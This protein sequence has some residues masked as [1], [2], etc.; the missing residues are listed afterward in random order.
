MYSKIG[1]I[2]AVSVALFVLFGAKIAI[3]AAIPQENKASVFA[4]VGEVQIT[5]PVYKAEF[6]K[7]VRNRLFHNSNPSDEMIGKIQREVGARLVTNALVLN[8]AKLR[9]LQPDYEAV[10]QEVANFERKMA[11]DAGWQK[12][13]EQSLPAVKQRIE[14][15]NLVKKL[16]GVVRKAPAPDETEVKAYYEKHPEKFTAPKEQRIAVI[17]LRV[18]PS[19]TTNG[20][21]QTIEDAKGLA[22]RVRD[23]E[24]FA[25]LA[26]LYSKDEETYEQGGDM[27]Y[28]HVGMVPELTQEA[29]D[30]VEIGGVTEPVRLLEGVAIFKLLD[31]KQ[32]G[33]SAFD[34]VKQ[35]AADLLSVEN[36]NAAWITF[37][38]DLRK[39][40]AM[41]IDESRFLPAAEATMGSAGGK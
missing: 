18:D 26:K 38:A 35:R 30:K 24:D 7:E 6:D 41:N 22:Q 23:G 34:L 31:R 19:S 37:L 10:D 32:P 21:N 12:V 28:L 27:G 9:K 1:F 20:W 5:W 25:A 39:N 11:K 16:E 36:G 17:L 33:L 2:K 3:A 4:T 40:T 13:R 14:N 8:E 29:V 15:D